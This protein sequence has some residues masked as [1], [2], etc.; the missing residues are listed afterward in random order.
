MLST[1]AQRTLPLRATRYLVL[2]VPRNIYSRSNVIEIQ[3]ASLP[4]TTTISTYWGCVID[5]SDSLPP[6]FPSS[7][8][9]IY[10]LLSHCCTSYF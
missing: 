10:L 6:P 7:S 8:L 3:T 1:P 2:F 9:S 5:P 4:L